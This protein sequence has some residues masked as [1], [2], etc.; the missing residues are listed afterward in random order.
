M[1]YALYGIGGV[2]NFGCEAIVRGTSV[3]LKDVDPEAEVRY[4]SFD[5]DYDKKMLRDLELDVRPITRSDSVFLRGLNKALRTAA[6]QR[7]ALRVRCSEMIRDNDCLVSI[8]GD[9]YT[10]PVNMREQPAYPYYNELVEVGKR[11]LR[12]GKHVVV[13]GASVGPFGT[14]APAVDYYT[15]NL[16]RYDEIVCREQESVKYLSGLG[17]KNLAFLPDPAFL[18]RGKAHAY[19]ADAPYVGVNL[20]PL[21][22]REVYGDGSVVEVDKLICILH[23]V[24]TVTGKKVLLVPHVVSKDAGD[25][26]LRFLTKIAESGDFALADTSG[27]FLGAKTQLQQCCMVISARM[28]CCVNAIVEGIPAIFI[29]YSQKSAGMCEYVYGDKKWVLGLRDLE[30]GLL[31][32]VQEMY[33]NRASISEG[34]VLRNTEI[35]RYYED[36]VSDTMLEWQRSKRGDRV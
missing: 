33:Q 8:G 27:G 15:S 13:Y 30:S 22:F 1:K 9:I 20:S 17:L 6:S 25:D 29:S 10:I 23:E 24:E 28:H 35:R 19:D 32:M 3:Y 34:L 14:Y 7:Q 16:G 12:N 31:P 4:Y 2:Y 36:H 18:V 11:F 5:L 26:D 21:S